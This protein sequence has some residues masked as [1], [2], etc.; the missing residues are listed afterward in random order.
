MPVLK[1]TQAKKILEIGCDQGK[2]TS[3][4]IDYCK[5]CNGYLYGIDPVPSERITELQRENSHH[6]EF[7]QDLSLNAIPKISELDAILIDGDHNWYT[8]FNELLLIEKCF[9]KFPIIFLHDVGWPYA[10]RDMYYNPDNIPLAYQKPFKKKGIQFGK[11]ELCE[12]GGINA[13]FNNSIYENSIQNGVLTAIEDFISA[14]SLDLHFVKIQGFNGLGILID[15]ELVSKNVQL[16]NLLQSF[17]TSEAIARHLINLE[18]HI[19]N[20]HIELLSK[21]HLMS[22]RNRDLAAKTEEL[23]QTK[24]DLRNIAEN[25]NVVDSQKR[26]V[27]MKKNQLEMEKKQLYAEIESLKEDIL[28][29]KRK[30]TELNAEIEQ[31]KLNSK[32]YSEYNKQ[33]EN[34]IRKLYDGI[35]DALNSKRWKIGNFIVDT[36]KRLLLRK[37]LN[38]AYQFLINTLD[39][40]PESL[41]D[42]KEHSLYTGKGIILFSL[43]SLFKRPIKTVLRNYKA[44]RVMKNDGTMF[45]DENYY[46]Q[47]NHDV[48][49]FK[50]DPLIHYIYFGGTEGRNPNKNFDSFEYLACNDDVKKAGINPLVHYELYGKFEGRKLF[51][52]VN[53]SIKT[54]NTEKSRDKSLMLTIN[55]LVSIIMPTYN[56]ATV[57]NRAIDS[58][59][60]QTYS[61]FELIIVDD[62]STD[63]TFSLVNRLYSKELQSGHIKYFQQQNSGVSAARNYGLSKSRGE[64]IAYLDSDNEWMP[65]FLEEMLSVFKIENCNTAYCGIEVF[66]SFRGK[67]FTRQTTY[68]RSKLLEGN[69]IDLN[70]F[71]HKHL[72]FSQYGGFDTSLKRLVDWDFILRLTKLNPPA[73]VNR[74]LVKYYLHESLNNISNTVSL[75]LNKEKVLKNHNQERISNDIVS[76]KIAYVLWDFPS[77]SQTFVLNELRNLIDS[78]YDVKVYYKT[79]PDKKATLDFK[80]DHYQVNDSDEL[81]ELLRRDNRNII[82]SHFVYPACTLLAYPAAEKLEIPFTVMAHAV[83]IYHHNND[84]RNRIKEISQ[85]KYCKKVFVLGEYPKNYLL[86]RGVPIQKIMK[87]RQAVRYNLISDDEIYNSQNNV[88]TKN[89][90][91]ITRFVE[92][93][94]L[95]YLISAAKLL[96]NSDYNFTIYG[97]G[98]LEE[99]LRTQVQ[100]LGLK[101]VSFPGPLNSF[102]EVKE[103]YSNADLF[104]LPCIQAENGDMD[105]LPTVLLEAMAH[106]VPVISTDISVIPEVV[107]DNYSGFIVE[108]KN[109][110]QIADKINE[111]FSMSNEMLTQIKLNARNMVDQVANINDTVNA[112][113][114]IWKNNTIDIFM[115]TYNTEEYNDIETTQEIIR[116][117]IHYTSTPFNLTIVDNGSNKEFVQYLRELCVS[118]TNIRLI[119]LEENVYCGPASNIA[120]DH[121]TGMYSIYVCSKEGFVAKLGWERELINFMN[122]NSKIG[123]A[124]ELVSSPA[125]YNGRTYISKEWF[126][127]FRNQEYAHEN[128]DRE[129]KHVQGGIYILRNRVYQECGGFNLDLPHHYMDVEYSYYVE[130]CGWLLGSVSSIQSVTKKTRPVIEETLDESVVAVHPLTLKSVQ[131]LDFY[132]SGKGKVCNLCGWRGDSFINHVLACPSCMATAVERLLF[133]FLARSNLVYRNY[134]ILVISPNS[135]VADKLNLQRM[136]KNVKICNAKESNKYFNSDL[137]CEIIAILDRD[138]E[139]VD[140][141]SSFQT[142]ISDDSIVN[143]SNDADILRKGYKKSKYSIASVMQGVSM[144]SLNVYQK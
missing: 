71:I 36:S 105:G 19:A 72:L 90:I 5:E 41:I 40:I 30:V 121:A 59:L 109:P 80:I 38:P 93:K 22:V 78:G 66:D 114:D 60:K 9:A 87:I 85:S 46:L 20:E 101:N 123:L 73:F 39:E 107:K 53:S 3:N 28:L 64:Y 12:H 141:I 34:I 112:L 89:I 100:T 82:H 15:K 143:S 32:D 79:S 29:Q 98:P 48:R 8:V 138:F 62:G 42:K 88:E 81:V 99:E 77:F 144:N 68:D 25:L 52:T 104:V 26:Q 127:R 58:V 10:R 94:G 2:N 70:T 111:V 69:F 65:T 7:Y 14:T 35:V 142:I 119:E 74:I 54:Y 84:Q 16:N 49:S 139:N 47:H 122:R 120:L 140:I 55:E 67:H 124:G 102:N 117:V 23:D 132:M 116:R 75:D 21:N 45:Y 103:A 1:C 95:F 129:F 97:Y 11:A 31:I 128:L 76:M 56:R 115:V 27:E 6:F 118:H 57:I 63:N 24:K 113:I 134:G 4:L 83:D 13:S 92:K 86:E 110:Q 137:H 106:G 44:Y 133:R 33:L 61:N 108:Q 50:F 96:E 18:E 136:F 125:F 91:T 51:R 130:S 126:S 17:E 37:A 131:L 43:K 135:D